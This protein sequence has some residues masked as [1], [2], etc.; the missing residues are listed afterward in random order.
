MKIFIDDPQKRFNKNESEVELGYKSVIRFERGNS[1]IVVS[2]DQNTGFLTVRETG[3]KMFLT[4]N[5]ATANSIVI[6]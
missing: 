6:S 4:I 5:P 1:K 3:D 2:F